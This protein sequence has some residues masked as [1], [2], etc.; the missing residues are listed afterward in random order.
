ME[1]LFYFSRSEVTLEQI[2][3]LAESKGYKH[4]IFTYPGGRNYSGGRYLS[5][6][7]SVAKDFH[8]EEWFD[9][10]VLEPGQIDLLERLDPASSWMFSYQPRA[11]PELKAFLK[12]LLLTYG[13][14]IAQDDDWETI[15]DVDHLTDMPNEP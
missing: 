14:W 6:N 10:D 13:G 7:L 5:V 8:C 9:L 3:D 12:D 15:Y 11:M 4:A 1:D 2:Q